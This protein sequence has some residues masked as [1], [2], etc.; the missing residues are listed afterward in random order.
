MGMALEIGSAVGDIVGKVTA[1]L[2]SNSLDSSTKVTIDA[3]ESSNDFA[4]KAA[5][6]RAA[7]REHGLTSVMGDR[8][9]EDFTALEVPKGASFIDRMV[10]DQIDRKRIADTKELANRK[11]HNPSSA[12]G[13]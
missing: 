6:Q 8:K 3:M 4:G 2:V 11:D 5:E 13:N 9:P 1:P 12:S 10:L 7:S